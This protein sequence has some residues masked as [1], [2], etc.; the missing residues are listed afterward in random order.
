M[1]D[2]NFKALTFSADQPLCY[3]DDGR[4][5][6]RS[7]VGLWV[8]VLRIF[9]AGKFGIF[10]VYLFSPVSSLSSFQSVVPTFRFG[11][12]ARSGD[13]IGGVRHQIKRRKFLAL[14][15]YL[16]IK[17]HSHPPLCD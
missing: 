9:L 16:P 17:A 12:Y 3:G 5:A 10:F 1:S 2:D 6:A 8:T 13:N 14:E 11:E 7:R 4:N 15:D